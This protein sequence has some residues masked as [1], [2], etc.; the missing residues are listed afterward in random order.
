M[1]G[2]QVCLMLKLPFLYIKNR[3]NFVLP[4]LF[5]R[6][7]SGWLDRDGNILSDKVRS[8]MES[9]LDKAVKTF[10]EKLNEPHYEVKNASYHKCFFF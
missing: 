4:C 5:H 10:P 6:K 9:V 3:A 1:G 7:I 8:W 2:I